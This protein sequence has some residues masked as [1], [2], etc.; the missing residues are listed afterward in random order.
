VIYGVGTDMIEVKRVEKMVSKGRQYLETIFTEKE[1]DYCD[2]KARK[3]EH[4]AARYAAKE[5]I[6][7][8]LGT[9]WRDGLAYSEI[10]ILNDDLGKPEV[11]LHGEVKKLMD[12]LHI[13]RTFVSLSHI[14]ETAIAL[15]ILEI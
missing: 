1:M 10:E 5:A 15:A 6:L 14:R 8:A 3:S 12:H 2:G 13:N 9:G 4:Y 11:F 7:K